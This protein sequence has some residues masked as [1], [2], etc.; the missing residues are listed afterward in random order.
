MKTNLRT[1]A[2]GFALLAMLLVPPVHGAASLDDLRANRALSQNPPDWGQALTYLLQ[3]HRE[4][5]TNVER[6]RLIAG[7]LQNSNR[8]LAAM[9]WY[10]AYRS[11][12]GVDPEKAKNAGVQVE[13]LEVDVRSKM[14][15]LF[16]EAVNVAE[17]Q[18]KDR[19]GFQGGK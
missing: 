2:S 9:A 13:L 10:Q 12:P 11:A 8:P 15:Y 19:V 5:P 7:C 16:T 14:G 17:Q 1:M 3:A 18:I 6:Y 4:D